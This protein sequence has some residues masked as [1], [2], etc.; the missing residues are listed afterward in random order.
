MDE[1]VLLGAEER[2][3]KTGWCTGDDGVLAFGAGIGA[4]AAG[5]EMLCQ[6]DRD[7]TT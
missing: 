4:A 6:C 5:F 3:D 2:V 7:E 1:A